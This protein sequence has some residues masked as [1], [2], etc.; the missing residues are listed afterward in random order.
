MERGRVRV[1]R[2]LESVVAA[3]IPLPLPRGGAESLADTLVGLL[4]AAIDSGRLAPGT[5]LPSSRALAA[6][7]DVSRN[8]VLAAYAVLAERGLATGRHGS[9][10]YVRADGRP[11][12]AR[13]VP[14]TAPWLER[15]TPVREDSGR[16]GPVLDL[17]L[18]ARP[19][20][21]LPTAVWRRA[22]QAAAQRRLPSGYG[23]PAGDRRLRAALADYLV[24]GRGVAAAPADVVVTG[25]AAEALG[26]LLR[27]VIRTGDRVAVEEPG[28]PPFTR[29]ARERGAVVVPVPVDGDG[30]RVELV[31]RLDPPPRML[32]LTPAHQ[33]PTTAP[34]SGD[35]RRQL[36]SWAREQGVLLVEDDYGGEFTAAGPPALAASDDQGVVAYV[37]TLSRLLAPSLRTGYLVAPRP[38]AAA[39]AR[40]RGETDSYLSLPVQ[41][42]VAE[43]LSTG[44]L[45]RQ[46]RRARKLVAE[47]RTALSAAAHPPL[48]RGL[49]GGLHVLLDTADAQAEAECA[50]ALLRD[51]IL[52]DRLST[53]WYGPPAAT[54]L[55]LDY[56]GVAP[57]TLTRLVA[58]LDRL[59]TPDMT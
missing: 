40:L 21:A 35:R 33:F 13:P 49:G 54:G 29:M 25:G 1:E 7:A 53:Y 23:D 14:D 32:L 17:R 22:W 20:A 51:G 10:S 43:L 57:A 24:A 15:L 44:E 59:T 30:I 6:A 36:L 46:L 31:R 58:R 4:A 26:L 39:V 16:P 48:P 9:G 5:R 12:R 34:L 41:Q 11:R 38:L 28:Y 45:T 42:A 19:A 50:E 2:G 55:L 3:G 18:R 27:A 8:V 56:A 47:Q 37:G 52:V